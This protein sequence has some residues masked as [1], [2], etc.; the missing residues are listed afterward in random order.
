IVVNLQ[1]ALDLNKETYINQFTFKIKMHDSEDYLDIF[2]NDVKEFASQTD[3][4]FCLQTANIGGVDSQIIPNQDLR[5]V[6]PH[7]QVDIVPEFNSDTQVWEM[8]LN[9]VYTNR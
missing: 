4:E 1:K 3:V 6:N 5:L 2:L 8:M 9:Q 7:Y